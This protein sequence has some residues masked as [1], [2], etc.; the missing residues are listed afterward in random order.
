MI[1]KNFL[2]PFLLIPFAVV[3]LL[4]STLFNNLLIENGKNYLFPIS[5]RGL[6]LVPCREDDYHS[7]NKRIPENEAGRGRRGEVTRKADV[8]R[9]RTKN[10]AMESITLRLIDK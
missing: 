4:L 7:K 1:L 8:Y 5:L 6:M 3:G 2:F 9:A 10:R